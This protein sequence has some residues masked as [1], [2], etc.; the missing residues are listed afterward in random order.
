MA[1]QVLKSKLERAKDDVARAEADHKAWAGRLAQART[2]VA[3]VEAG[4]GDSVLES[5]DVGT[6][7]R[8]LAELR[9]K[10]EACEAAVAS[11]AARV[12]D[13]RRSALLAEADELRAE[14]ARIKREADARQRRTDDLLG[15]L[16]EF[17]GVDYIVPTLPPLA[18]GEQTG[19]WAEG[20]G[21]VVRV[22]PTPKTEI[23]RAKASQLEKKAA[24]LERKAG[25]PRVQRSKGA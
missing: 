15:Q 16:R 12:D 8:Q 19:S 18:K 21:P 6:Y 20:G 4:L 11:S 14:A 1:V 13:K 23:M 9:A 17:E 25:R 24:D 7:G 3:E 2:N 10:V 22:K 5:G